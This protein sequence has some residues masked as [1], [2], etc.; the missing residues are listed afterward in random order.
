M[1]PLHSEPLEQTIIEI[2]LKIEGVA[3]NLPY[4]LTERQNT[5]QES[6]YPPPTINSFIKTPKQKQTTSLFSQD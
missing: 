2:N 1:R 5:R 6:L 4:Q 3:C